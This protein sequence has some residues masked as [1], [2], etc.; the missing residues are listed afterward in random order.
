MNPVGN[1]IFLCVG[2][3]SLL[4]FWPRTQRIGKAVL[5]LLTLVF[6]AGIYCTLTRCVWL[7]AGAGLMI[8]V[9]SRL[10]RRGTI[11][12]VVAVALSGVLMVAA[13]WDTLNSFK[14]D[15]DVS[16][17]EMSQSASLRPI[18]AYIAWQMFLDRP[19]T[20]CGYR[21]YEP[22]SDLYLA[23][24]STP[25]KL[26][27]GRR[28]VQHNVFLSLLAETGMIGAGLFVLLLAALC[29]ASWRL[30]RARHVPLAY[31]QQGLLMF[32]MLT[33]YL[34]MAMFHDLALIPMVHMLI[35]LLAG[36]TRGLLP[37]I[38]LADTAA[39][40]AADSL[41]GSDPSMCVPIRFR[42]MLMHMRVRAVQRRTFM[43]VFGLK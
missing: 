16:A 23:D 7:A 3:F 4:M 9:V 6:L 21:H 15:R 39:E 19:L 41:C 27:R 18:L 31:R 8:M 32:V 33:S 40:Q 17:A 22:S 38:G 14:R 42:V 36:I 2:M 29:R 30:L 35:F 12:L 13:R 20:G 25:L 1:G 37:A 24:R 28:Y 5:L 43:G 11:A 10:P 34:A 26:E